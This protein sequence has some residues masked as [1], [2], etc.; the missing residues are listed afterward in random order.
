MNIRNILVLMLAKEPGIGTDSELIELESFLRDPASRIIIDRVFRDGVTVGLHRALYPENAAWIKMIFTQLYP[1]VPIDV[2]EIEGGTHIGRN[3]FDTIRNITDPDSTNVFFMDI[4]DRFI[5]PNY[6]MKFIYP[7]V[8]NS[9]NLLVDINYVSDSPEVA[10][11][12]DT[13][14]KVENILRL[15]PW[16]PNNYDPITGYKIY[17]PKLR[18]SGNGKFF[19]LG[20]CNREL[21][22]QWERYEDSLFYADMY[23]KM[24]EVVL[25]PFAGIQ[26]IRGCS[27]VMTKDAA[28]DPLLLKLVEVAKSLITARDCCPVPYIVLANQ[29]Q[30]WIDRK[31][32]ENE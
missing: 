15:H 23:S 28:I 12:P 29:I 24:S 18:V 19:R 20:Y 25:M 9:G 11:R 31:V 2:V 17:N 6:W 27:S 1:K 16:D 22:L 21:L 3:R 32:K 4:D 13:E 30:S 10:M 8:L 14:E 5:N 26:Y 7:T